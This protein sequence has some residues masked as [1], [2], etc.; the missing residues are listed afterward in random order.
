MYE[1]YA[2]AVSHIKKAE[3]ALKTLKSYVEKENAEKT[4]PILNQIANYVHE[5]VTDADLA[6]HFYCA[7]LSISLACNNGE[8]VLRTRSVD[9]MSYGMYTVFT[10]Q[11]DGGIVY[12]PESQAHIPTLIACWKYFKKELLSKVDLAV[13]ERKARIEKELDL[14]AAEQ[15]LYAEFKL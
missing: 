13:K 7:T 1:K 15:R 5:V 12:Y 9:S 2:E 3:D 11:Q 8:F 4:M 14:L 6:S 10:I